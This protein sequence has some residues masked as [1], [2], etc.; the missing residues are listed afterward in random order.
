MKKFYL[1]SSLSVLSLSAISANSTKK[2]VRK[3]QSNNQ[4]C[5]SLQVSGAEINICLSGRPNSSLTRSDL[6]QVQTIANSLFKKALRTETK[7]M[8]V[9]PYNYESSTPAVPNVILNEA[10]APCSSDYGEDCINLIPINWNPNDN[11]NESESEN[12]YSWNNTN[13]EIPGHTQT[14]DITDYNE[15]RNLS[16]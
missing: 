4:A 2:N 3:L 5:Q 16:Q 13:E 6:T 1:I 14:N 10:S 7:A 12:N 9:T 11:V 8:S 15:L